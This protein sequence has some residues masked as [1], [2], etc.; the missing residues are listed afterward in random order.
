MKID[1]LKNERSL[2]TL[3]WVFL[4]LMFVFQLLP[5]TSTTQ[6][7]LFPVIMLSTIYPFSTYLS[8]TLL[9]RAMRSKNMKRFI[10]QFLALSFIAGSCFFGAIYLFHYLEEIGYFPHSDYFDIPEYPFYF[11]SIFISAG[12]LLNLCICGYQFFLENVKLQKTLVESQLQMLQ[13]QI[14]PHFMFN[15]LNH[16]HYYIE[17]KDDLASTL[18]LKYA[19]TLRYQLYSGRKEYVSLDEE[20]QFLKNFIGVEEIRWE[21]K[22]DVQCSWQIEDARVQL[23]PLLFITFIENAFKHVSRTTSE[24][25]YI[26]INFVQEGDMVDLEVEN[27]KSV[28]TVKKSHDWGLGLENIKKRLDILYH[29]NYKLTVKETD[30][31]YHT[32]L[33]IK[34]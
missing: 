20:V 5:Q 10:Y 2:N 19:D 1:W 22:L 14:N 3:L 34:L 29:T 31:V 27:S 28:L 21:G 30:L 26:R 7:L 17:K 12:V 11:F 32:Q 9:Q 18:L 13:E 23:S 15:V 16:I 8:R 24:Q 6:A 4:Y 25:G 33:T